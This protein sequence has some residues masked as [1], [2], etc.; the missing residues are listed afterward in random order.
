MLY[1]FSMQ[2]CQITFNTNVVCNLMEEIETNFSSNVINTEQLK[3][4]NLE[5]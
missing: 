4:Y 2:I 1:E 3:S 5:M